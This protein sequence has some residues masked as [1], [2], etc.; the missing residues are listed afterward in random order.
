MNKPLVCLMALAAAGV[1]AQEPVKLLPGPFE[2]PARLGPLVY[3]GTPS[4]FDDPRLG[5]GYNYNAD[6][7][8]LSIYV[9]DAGVPDI[10]DGAES[11]PTC[12][13]YEIAKQ[14][15]QQTPTYKNAVLKTEQLVRL[16]PPHDAP[17]AREAVFEL[18]RE[19]GHAASYV[20]ITGAAKHFVKLRFTMLAPHFEEIGEARRAILDVF[21]DAIRP[22]LA[23]VDP[24]AKKPGSSLSLAFDPSASSDDMGVAFGYLM[25]M[26]GIAE[27][28]TANTPVCGGPYVPTF[29]DELAAYQGAML[30]DGEAGGKSK[31]LK[32]LAKAAEAGFLEELVWT[33]LHRDSW[34]TTA[35]EGL[36]LTKYEPWR[37]KN[38]KKLKVPKLGSVTIDH[39]R[40]LPLE[41]NPPVA[42]Q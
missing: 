28:N 15:V 36:T 35:P 18:D 34:G 22:H 5:V 23:P 7:A 16:S 33:E 40:P 27:E 26:N 6:G 4:K 38:V 20:W 19:E 12:L 25:F 17:L 32:T 41:P 11:I 37:K 39:P 8:R 30:M 10:P 21:G 1:Q 13:E 29:E 14:G 9:Y 24:A 31:F 3:S 42:A 2:L